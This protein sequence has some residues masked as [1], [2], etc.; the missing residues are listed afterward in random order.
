MNVMLRA[1]SAETLKLR[2]TLALWMCLI[3]PATVTMLLVMQMT[4]A[5][6]DKPPMTA[7]HAW[8]G[9]SLGTMQLWAFLMLPLFITLQ[10]GLL[11]GLEHGNQQWK[12]LLALP[13]PKSVHY[14][15][16]H[17]TLL[18]MVGLAM[19]VL[20]AL[21]PLGGALIMLLRPELGFA[22]P[23]PWGQIA[24]GLGAVFAAALLIIALQ[25]WAAIRWRNF[26]VVIAIGMIAT[27]V[28]FLAMQSQRYGHYYP[29]SMP[30]HA[31]GGKG[32]HLGFVVTVG[33]LG[34]PLV[35]LASLWDLLRRDEA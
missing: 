24:R 6:Y 8:A 30:L 26:T 4:L 14:L 25:T 12:H 35:V 23:P 3:A 13:I 9:Y 15:A 16:K 27:V 29:W 10:S 21:I 5:P 18:G 31:I 34:W 22:G 1:L 7:H 32:E 2:G 33:L 11:A 20:F 28:G 17:A 19:I